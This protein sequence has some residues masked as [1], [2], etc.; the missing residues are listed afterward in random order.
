M[1][2]AFRS[3]LM[4]VCIAVLLAV[5]L[6]AQSVDRLTGK[7]VSIKPTNYK[8]RS[9]IQIIATAGA[10][11]ATSYA[12]VK[13]L[14]F[15]TASQVI[16]AKSRPRAISRERNEHANRTRELGVPSQTPHRY[17]SF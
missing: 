8:G 10:E 9:A 14:L 6:A 5:P 1:N 16:S 13:D 15:L 12:T 2:I 17:E 4:L 7:N 3:A 11:N